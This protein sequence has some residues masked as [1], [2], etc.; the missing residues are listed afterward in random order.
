M[1]K[2]IGYSKMGKNSFAVN[3][4]YTGKVEW[5]FAYTLTLSVRKIAFVHRK[6]YLY[7]IRLW[8]FAVC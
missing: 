7:A 4:F 8:P 3:D 5:A 6:G 1:K 2:A